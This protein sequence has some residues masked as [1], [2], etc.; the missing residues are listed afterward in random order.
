MPVQ[1]ELVEL[2]AGEVSAA[3]APGRQDA[4]RLPMRVIDVV[5]PKC[6]VGAGVACVKLWRLVAFVD[7]PAFHLDRWESALAAV[8]SEGAVRPSQVD[9]AY[10]CR[11]GRCTHGPGECGDPGR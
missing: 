6:Y 11:I 7:G 8:R 4:G 10:L 9:P 3:L 1:G 2:V 5:C